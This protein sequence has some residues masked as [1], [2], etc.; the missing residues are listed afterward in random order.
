MAEI[1]LITIGVLFV[2]AILYSV[3]QVISISEDKTASKH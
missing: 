2:A 3:Y 1:S